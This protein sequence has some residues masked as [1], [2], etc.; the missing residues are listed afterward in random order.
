[1]KKLSVLALMLMSWVLG[2]AQY[3]MNVFQKDGGT[4]H[5]MV[6]DLDSV[7]FSE[8]TEPFENHEYV[9]L[10]LSVNWATCNVGA[11]AEYESGNYYTWGATS[12]YEIQKTKWNERFDPEVNRLNPGDDVASV[13][14][15][16][17]WRMP[18]PEE[19]YELRENC[20][21]TL[22]L[23]EGMLGY[24]VY[25][26]RE[27]YTDSYIF[28]P[29][30]GYYIDD[31]LRNKWNGSYGSGHYWSS[32]INKET[33]QPEYL[34]LLRSAYTTPS[35]VGDSI[36]VMS[37]PSAYDGYQIQFAGLPIRP[38][39]ASD[40]WKNSQLSI[41]KN[42]MTLK[43]GN[44]SYLNANVTANGLQLNYQIHYVSSDTLVATVNE[45]GVVT[46]VSPGIACITV[47]AGSKTVQCDVTVRGETDVE[48]VDL[49]LS[50]C[51]ATCNV[52]GAVT[53]EGSIE[54]YAFG[55][56]K[57]RGNVTPYYPMKDYKFFK[58]GKLTKYCSDS[59]MGYNGFT[60]NKTE[61]DPEDDVAYI[62]W[63]SNWRMPSS[64][65][66]KELIGNCTWVWTTQNGVEGYE[67]TSNLA[68]FTDR[69]IFLQAFDSRSFDDIAHEY[70]ESGPYGHYW[71]RSVDKSSYTSILHID[72]SH[73]AMTNEGRSTPHMVRPV[74]PSNDWGSHITC[75]LNR[76]AVT[77]EKN[78][79]FQ[80]LADVKYDDEP[81]SIEATWS[82]DNTQVAVVSEDGKIVAISPGT[83]HI[84][85]L[86]GNE[87]VGCTVTVLEKDMAVPEYVDL[88]LSVN[89]A[90]FNVGASSP[91]ESGGYY[92][93]G[94]T[95]TKSSYSWSS[96]K[97]SNGTSEQLT[98][99]CSVGTWGNNGF[100]DDKT[101][102]D[103]EDD[104]AHVN[105]GGEW[106]MPTK[107][108][109]N[110]LVMNTN[111]DTVT[112]N[113]VQGMLFTSKL[114]GHTDKSIFIPNTGFRRGTGLFGSDGKYYWTS[115]LDT[116][117][118]YMSY[119][120]YEPRT[121][122]GVAYGDRQFG[123]CVRPVCPSNE[124]ESHIT[125]SINTSSITLLRSKT[126]QVP[127]VVHYDDGEYTS[128]ESFDTYIP[129]YREY[130]G[131]GSM[132]WTS[133]DETVVTVDANGVL[134]PQSPG[135]AHI[136]ASLDS[137]SA[138]CTVTIVGEQDIQHNY[139]DLGLSVKWADCNIGAENPEDYGSYFAWGETGAKYYFS[140]SNYKYGVYNNLT[141][142]CSNSESGLNGFTD[143]KTVLEMADDVARV[144]WG[145]KWRMP[146]MDEFQELIDS[147]TWEWTTQNGVNGYRVTS[148]KTGYSDRSIFL[149]AAGERDFYNSY[150]G[151]FGYYW[152]DL[153]YRGSN[154]AGYMSF[155]P[156]YIE[157][158]G[159]DRT[160]GLPV[161]PVCP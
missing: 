13:R 57:N 37:G 28:L 58:D 161:R 142:Y 99:Y 48:Y 148:N 55:D 16:D 108:E 114:P 104:A 20:T 44:H 21:W 109:W 130:I 36:M 88:G 9:D 27:G 85:A 3:Y 157:M 10:G 26:K 35:Y 156:D 160:L 89:W 73:N 77:L 70:G 123:Y 140:W 150:E 41:S 23:N 81:Y 18:T 30:S 40:S 143:G 92:A 153:S 64:I 67:I 42:K 32:S 76:N 39:K 147:C 1:M 15:G 83:A 129:G 53:A 79:V 25:G 66:F 7:N 11:H 113:G 115:S 80:L 132:T 98:K 90:T 94:E 145:G 84:T 124:W 103:P 17:G 112:L 120:A 29:L 152:S 51:W 135:V 4:F 121:L 47:S 107:D 14:W 78:G 118:L 61:L 45:N 56:L 72:R 131:K 144:I 159:H 116:G 138:M 50:V 93:W 117:S 46:G 100:T 146:T 126:T 31:M 71:S 63:G 75:S 2:N 102:L 122:G 65:E 8:M 158:Y 12:S 119:F 33:K 127:A 62:K 154:N 137:K 155:N 95:E 97:Y 59:D 74:C 19:F 125:V 101:V 54:K 87:S 136:T 91:E 22:S 38:V 105:W 82:S 111:V 128:Y 134:T 69:S 68:G 139:V 52:G 96:Y 110:E 49:G 106:R 133:D 43:I 151:H 86:I 141:K 5:F 60:D 6:M 149:P 24:Y 34:Y